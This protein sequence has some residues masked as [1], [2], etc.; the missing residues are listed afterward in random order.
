M[1]MISIR[2]AALALF[3]LA[4]IPAG[5][6]APVTDFRSALPAAIRTIVRAD[7]A[8]HTQVV[9]L[10]PR[11]AP[12]RIRWTSFTHGGGAYLSSMQATLL[13]S[14]RYDSIRVDNPTRSVLNHGTKTAPNMGAT[15]I[16]TWYDHDRTG[17]SWGRHPFWFSARGKS[18]SLQ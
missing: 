14:A 8:V 3:A 17:E 10:G 5:P 11:R 9:Y 4:T 16:L 7:T 15:V 6:L 2:S 13:S 18:S 1:L 12:V